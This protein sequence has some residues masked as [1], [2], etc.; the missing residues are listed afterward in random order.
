MR[1]EVPWHACKSQRRDRRPAFDQQADRWA[2][3][4]SPLEQAALQSLLRRRLR[5]DCD[6]AFAVQETSKATHCIDKQTETQGTG[7]FEHS[8]DR[9]QPPSAGSPADA[10]AS[11][12]AVVLLR[13]T[14]SGAPAARPLAQVGVVPPM[15]WDAAPARDH[16]QSR[17]CGH[18]HRQLNRLGFRGG[19]LS[20]ARPAWTDSL[21]G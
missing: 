10:A 4:L 2:P 16:L 14:R 9:L 5:P 12:I 7:K 3:E 17:Y 19:L 1:A 15:R 20:C 13:S 6:A 21:L 18:E 11:V 8:A